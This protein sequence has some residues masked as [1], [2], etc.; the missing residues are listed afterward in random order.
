MLTLP[1]F[2]NSITNLLKSNAESRKEARLA[3]RNREISHREYREVMNG[4]NHDRGILLA[5]ALE[6]SMG[7]K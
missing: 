1:T 2:K 5:K 6:A 4:L 7:M 3:Y